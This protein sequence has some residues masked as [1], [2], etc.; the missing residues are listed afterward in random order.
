[1]YR[2]SKSIESP[3][4]TE[5]NFV[6]KAYMHLPVSLPGTR[7]AGITSAA[8]RDSNGGRFVGEPSRWSM[9]VSCCS[10]RCCTCWHFCRR[11]AVI[12]GVPPYNL[13]IPLQ[14]ARY[15]YEGVK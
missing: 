6:E 11:T 15:D 4:E 3:K 7:A 13:N 5:M 10:V 8:G 9:R 1:M 12:F 14:L 2:D